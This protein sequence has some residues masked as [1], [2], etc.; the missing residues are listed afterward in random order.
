MIRIVLAASA[1]VCFVAQASAQEFDRPYWLDRNV[2]ESLNTGT[3]GSLLPI[4]NTASE[5][6]YGN[7]IASLPA[8]L[9]VKNAVLGIS[10]NPLL[11]AT[12][13]GLETNRRGCLVADETGTT[14]RPGVFAGGDIVSGAATVI[15]AMGQGKQAAL[16]MH[17]YLMGVDPPEV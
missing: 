16:N 15:S 11:A 7:V 17:R 2:I 10:P 4:F 12:T 3:M 1:A 5:V 14:T 9:V 13:P 8:F 6:G